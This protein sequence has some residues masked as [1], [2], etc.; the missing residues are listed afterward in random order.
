MPFLSLIGGAALMPVGAKLAQSMTTVISALH[1]LLLLSS[2]CFGNALS[3][4]RSDVSSLRDRL[5][6]VVSDGFPHT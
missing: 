2:M 6:L 5:L 4:M 3:S 1:I